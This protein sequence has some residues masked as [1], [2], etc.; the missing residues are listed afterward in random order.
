M[1]SQNNPSTLYLRKPIW[2]AL[3]TTTLHNGTNKPHL[4]LNPIKR[5]QREKRVHRL[6][7]RLY[8]FCC[9]GHEARFPPPQ[10]EVAHDSKEK[11]EEENPD[12]NLDEDSVSNQ[13]G[14]TSGGAGASDRL[15]GVSYHKVGG[16][17]EKVPRRIGSQL[18]QQRVVVKRRIRIG[19]EVITT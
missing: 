16:G 4:A 14:H 11:E 17:K 8:R 9:Q 7:G 13:E 19:T 12:D 18:I 5:V 3:S 15:F 1:R 6:L 2:K 10:E